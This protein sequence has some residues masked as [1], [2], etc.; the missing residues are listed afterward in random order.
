LKHVEEYNKFIE[1]KNLCIKLVIKKMLSKIC[2]LRLAVMERLPILVLYI[3]MEIW[4][5]V[6]ARKQTAGFGIMEGLSL[7]MNISPSTVYKF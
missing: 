2:R 3:A 7:I 6:K 1:I 4:N 5:S